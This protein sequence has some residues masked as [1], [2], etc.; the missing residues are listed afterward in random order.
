MRLSLNDVHVLRLD[1]DAVSIGNG[2]KCLAPM[3]ELALVLSPDEQDRA[4]R[5]HFERDRR[6]FIA[7]RGLLRFVLGSYLG[8]EPSAVQ[9]CHNTY[10]KPFLAGTLAESGLAFSLTHSGGIAFIAIANQRQIGVDL[11]QC[12]PQHDCLSLAEQF[13]ASREIALLR[14]LGAEAVHRTFLMLW[15]AK[16][17]YAKALG[18][19]LSLPLDQLEIDASLDDS[20]RVVPGASGCRKLVEWSVQPL[21]AGPGFV[22]V[23]VV[24]GHGCLVKTVDWVTETEDLPWRLAP[25]SQYNQISACATIE[26]P[27][28]RQ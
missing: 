3:E 16:E 18:S 5:Y 25:L 24:E 6:R 9:Y 20:L 23:L 1:L 14:S 11:E 2:H 17:A 28:P 21:D 7:R 19:G 13:F 8:I 4:A 10:G 15:T 22:A 12:C 27:S 26:C